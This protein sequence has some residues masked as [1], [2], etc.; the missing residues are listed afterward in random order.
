MKLKIAFV[1]AILLAPTAS[2]AMGCSG[3]KHKQAMSCAE[4][5]AYDS[6]THTCLPVST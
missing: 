1:T 5:T 6:A 4:G 2:L 3:G